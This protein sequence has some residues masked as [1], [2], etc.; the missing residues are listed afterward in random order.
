[1][2]LYSCTYCHSRHPF[3][4][5]SKGDQMCKKCRKEHPLVT[6]TYCRMEFHLVGGNEQGKPVCKKCNGH[7]LKYGQPACCVHCN[8]RAA[9]NGSKCSRCESSERKYGPPIQ[10]EQ[11]KLKCAFKKSDESKDKVDGKILCLLCTL[12]YKRL[13]HRSKGVKELLRGQSHSHKK[14]TKREGHHHHRHHHKHEKKAKT[15]LVESSGARDSPGL[16]LKNTNSVNSDA[17][18]EHNLSEHMAELTDVKEMVVKLKKQLQQK[19]QAL[20]EKEKKITEIKAENWEKEKEFKK[21]LSSLQK[22]LNDRL[23]I[24][25][26]E[27]RN[28]KKQLSQQQVQQVKKE[29]TATS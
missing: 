6:C 2:S 22:E 24:L 25:Q 28:L 19:D 26:T 14:G 4:E 10:C 7:V 15:D 17:G 12:A 5:L 29:K 11:C 27:N 8:I 1:M 23:E 20:I 13:V 16:G 3:E 9:F 21:K 18:T